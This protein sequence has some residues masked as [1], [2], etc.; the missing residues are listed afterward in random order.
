MSKTI[1]LLFLFLP[2]VAFTQLKPLVS[3]GARF[4]V[5]GYFT[6]LN[7]GVIAYEKINVQLFAA[8]GKNQYYGLEVGCNF[9]K[10]SD[11]ISVLVTLQA[12]F[13]NGIFGIDYP[14]IETRFMVK[15]WLK[16]AIIFS[17]SRIEAKII[18]IKFDNFKE[19]PSFE[20]TFSY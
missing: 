16:P 8:Y 19:K 1:I 6:T 11:P 9:V 4:G 15:K 13:Y 18:L 7:T 20:D 12:G 3:A 2:L 17:P 10:D 5:G 14:A